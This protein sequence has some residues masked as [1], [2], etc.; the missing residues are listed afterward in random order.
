MF[1]KPGQGPL[2][3][4]GRCGGVVAGPGVIKKGVLGPFIEL[5]DIFDPIAVKNGVHRPH[6]V[7]RDAVIG[8]EKGM[9]R[10]G[11]LSRL[12]VPQRPAVV[13]GA[14][15]DLRQSGRRLID[16]R[17]P[18]QKPVMPTLSVVKGWALR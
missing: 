16:E 8:A 13:G 12:I 15:V 1:A 3:G 9:D 7:G 18:I 14:G 6:R 17:P 2:P 10:G 5:E 11:D 4:I